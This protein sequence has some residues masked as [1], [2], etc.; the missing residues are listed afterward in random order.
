LEPKDVWTS[1]VRLQLEGPKPDLAMFN[2]AI[3]G[4]TG[5]TSRTSR[6]GSLRGS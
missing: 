3:D 2:L 4:N 5:V 6:R 1:R